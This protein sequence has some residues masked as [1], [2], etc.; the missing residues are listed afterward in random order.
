MNFEQTSPKTGEQLQLFGTA[1]LN[2]SEG[3]W[4]FLQ[5]SGQNIANVLFDPSPQIV[6][7]DTGTQALDNAL[8]EL[9]ALN[10]N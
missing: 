8:E 3:T 2:R 10:Q 1:Q 5:I 9:R 6:T 7:T 4:D